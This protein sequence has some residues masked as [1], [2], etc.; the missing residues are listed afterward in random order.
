[1]DDFPAAPALARSLRRGRMLDQLV[2]IDTYRLGLV[3]AP[4]GYGK[5]T[6]LDQLT[7]LVRAA[8]VWFGPDHVEADEPALL[9]ALASLLPPAVAATTSWQDVDE[10]VETLDQRLMQ[11]SLLLVDNLHELSGTPVA[12]AILRLVGRLPSRLTV[13]LAS[14]RPPDLDVTKLRLSG[15]LVEITADDLRFRPWE[16]ERL[17]RDHYRSAI[18]PEEAATLTTRTEGWVAG[19]QLFNLATKNRPANERRKLLS[20]LNFR[21]TLVREYLARNVLVELDPRLRSFLLETSVL[22][23]LD[24]G[25]CDDLLG[26]DDSARVLAE[27]ER[28]ALFTTRLEDGSGFRYHEALRA[29]LGALLIEDV[30]EAEVRALH[31]RAGMLLEDRGVLQ[32][33]AEAYCRAEDWQAVERLLGRKGDSLADGDARWLDHV[34]DTLAGD[35]WILLAEARRLVRRGDWNAAILRYR[36][37]EDSFVSPTRAEACRRERTIVASWLDEQPVH[38]MDALGIL[39]QAV[40]RSPH[41][42]A[43][44]AARRHD[45]ASQ[46]VAA[47]CSLLAGEVLS[48]H[49]HAL[50]AM[51]DA[52]AEPLVASIAHA[53]SG[54]ASWAAGD[55]GGRELVLRGAE[56]LHRLGMTWLANVVHAATTLGGG[57]AVEDVSA[58]TRETIRR[59]DPWGEGLSCLFAGY[60]T[61]IDGEPRPELFDQAI[62]AF[63]SVGARV[64]ESWGLSGRALALAMRGSPAATRV[65]NT[66]DSLARSCGA[67]GP[68]C[69]ALFAIATTLASTNPA[70]ARDIAEMAQAMAQDLGVKLGRKFPQGLAVDVNAGTRPALTC[71]GSFGLRIDDRD[72]DVTT[73]K[74]R[75]R[76]VLYVLALHLGEK[77]HRESLVEWIWPD[78]PTERG[79]HNVQVAVSSIRKLLAPDETVNSAGII[80]QGQT[81]R[82]ELPAGQRSDLQ[83]FEE[84]L[85]T[86]TQA[87][88]NGDPKA[89]IDLCRKLRDLYRGEL[90]PE[91]G[92]AEWVVHERD[93]YH[94]AAGEAALLLA[95]CLEDL[96]HYA[97]AA[98]VC[99]EAV[100]THPYHDGMWRLGI[101]CYERVG[102]LAAATTMRQRY[103]DVLAELG[104]LPSAGR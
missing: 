52:S 94:H 90:L 26:R 98:S 40:V 42:A 92:S 50:D 57:S 28:R 21:P 58:F 6:L 17:F 18:T 48:A 8:H 99:S 9:G 27:L 97:E 69:I 55:P 102:N 71:F 53:I 83:L 44:Q 2:P 54:L 103:D 74:P 78:V 82:L 75:A 30:G 7:E 77:V 65:A 93:R 19:L 31:R 49:E 51:E 15:G 47:V 80:R 24:P 104:V 3:V 85:A 64:P 43:A 46:V 81:Y 4:A 35:P 32:E 16:V 59:D 86:A 72:V 13:V 33:A 73:V 25:L 87:R 100:S 38:R 5:S 14:R 10:A 29:H 20:A 56:G 79:I 88:N 89:C 101:R 68:Q 1:M 96:E 36:A 84:T 11:P 22:T 76:E 23:R 91:A 12:D 61:L 62:A 67:A 60:G 70:R 34:P 37:A 66:A 41:H 63:Q 45:S 39:R 95:T